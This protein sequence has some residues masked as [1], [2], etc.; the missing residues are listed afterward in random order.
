MLRESENFWNGALAARLPSD[1]G[2]MRWTL[3][4]EDAIEDDEDDDVESR[5][6]CVLGLATLEAKPKLDELQNDWTLESDDWVGLMLEGVSIGDE[7]T[8]T[9]DT[10]R[11][12]LHYSVRPM[13]G[14]ATQ[15]RG[16]GEPTQGSSHMCLEGELPWNSAGETCAGDWAP[17]VAMTHSSAVVVVDAN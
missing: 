2:K 6:R 12:V 10:T 14:R 1:E 7:F 4:I 9:A 16:V 5:L 3:R 11:S 15:W 13:G 8:F 17:I